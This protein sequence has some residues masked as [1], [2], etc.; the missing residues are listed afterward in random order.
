[1]D[2]P[3]LRWTAL[4]DGAAMPL[5]EFGTPSGPPVLVLPGLTD[6]CA[7]LTDDRTRAAIPRPPRELRDRRVVMVS[8]RH[9]IADGLSTTDLAADVVRVLEQEFAGRP[10][11][12]S[13]HSMGAMVAQHVAARRPDLVD[14]LTLSG[15]V[16]SADTGLREVLCRWDALLVAGRFRD[17]LRDALEISYT[18]ADLRR[19]RLFLRLTSAPD[20]TERV[21]R[22]L[23]LSAACRRHDAREELPG[24]D[25][26]TLL[27]AGTAD[28]LT[29]VEHA[30]ELAELLPRA[31]LVEFEGLA[32][33]FPEQARRRYVREL[34]S[35]L[36]AA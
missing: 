36:E 2:A 7:P 28:R 14:R 11:V 12:V 5:I 15:A 33:G 32:H 25:V 23:V 30:R 20:L 27:L 24:V 10:V 16:A 35:F 19:R 8:Y 1:M 9:P 31:R 4:P 17:F 18:G 3:T 6:G 26:P 34:S 21:P 13:A 29:R 22:H